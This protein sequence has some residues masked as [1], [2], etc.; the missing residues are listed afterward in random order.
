MGMR[1]DFHD[2][3]VQIEHKWI[4]QSVSGF[5]EPGKLLAVMGPSGS[6]KTVL[7]TT[8]AGRQSCQAGTV[9]LDGNSLDKKLRRK[10]GFV[11]QDDVFLP[12]L[13]LHETLMYTARLRLPSN[14]KSDEVATRVRWV[15]TKLDLI[16]CKNTRIGN[17]SNRGLSGGEKKRA[18]IAC[19]LLHQPA[20][21][22]LDEPTS[23]LDSDSAYKLIKLLKKIAISS[24]TAIVLSIHQPSSSVFQLFDRVVLVLNGE[25]VFFGKAKS[26]VSYFGS[27][28]LHC[29]PSYN[30]A[31]FIM[32][33]LK[34]TSEEVKRLQN[35][36]HRRKEN[37]INTTTTSIN[38]SL[39]V[40]MDGRNLR[41]QSRRESVMSVDILRYFNEDYRSTPSVGDSSES[42]IFRCTK[43][44]RLFRRLCRKRSDGWGVPTAQPYDESYPTSFLEQYFLLTRRSFRHS[45]KAVLSTLEIIR[46]ICQ[47]VI[48]G[49]LWFQVELSEDRIGDIQAVMFFC[50]IYWGFESIY[51]AISTFPS[52]H[53]VID[54]ERASGSYRLSSYYLAKMTSELPLV[55]V[56]PT[57]FFAIVYW[58][59]LWNSNLLG[60]FLSWGFI[61]LDALVAQSVGLAISALTSSID[62]G[63]AIGGMYML[64]SLLISGFYM[65]ILPPWL[66][67]SRYFAFSY[68]SFNA[69]LTLAFDYNDEEFRCADPDVASI[70]ECKLGNVTFI[71]GDKI[72]RQFEPLLLPLW[73]NGIALV[74]LFVII[75]VLGYLALRYINRPSR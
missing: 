21:L 16:K 41:L 26:V 29:P 23:G 28:G 11:L 62:Q 17:I 69:F 42:A 30:P 73:L 65:Q 7:L 40:V 74:G 15:E 12:N 6:G 48:V 13:S 14:R 63:I 18:S 39:F 1:L 3:S 47:A 33:K 71:T 32:E 20:V 49:L 24:Q 36:P 44:R 37:A 45:S 34:G 75:R 58:L 51:Q 56:M 38:P 72:S 64:T 67:W 10:I 19:E 31:D 68:Y 8:L 59:S 46:H 35:G 70:P 5:A 60:F 57:I 52:E 53:D 2:V 4:L 25:T 27:L 9:L 43:I 54:K 55:I 22:I 61:V 50:V 66:S